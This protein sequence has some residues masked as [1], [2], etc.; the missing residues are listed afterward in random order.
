VAVAGSAFAADA[1]LAVTQPSHFLADL[2]DIARTIVDRGFQRSP[3]AVLG[4]LV[5]L[6]LPL[7]GVSILVARRIVRRFGRKPDRSIEPDLTLGPSPLAGPAWLSVGGPR[8]R[9]FMLAREIHRIGR[10][11]DNDLTLTGP[12]GGTYAIIHRTPDQEFFVIDVGGAGGPGLKVN[13]NRCTRA[14]LANGDRI[15]F[16]PTHV[17]F[18]RGRISGASAA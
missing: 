13:G 10:D 7:T 9:E 17:T 8:R 16:G 3:F 15:G 12:A 6:A 2:P 5:G 4:L 1:A 14:A 11:E 18:H